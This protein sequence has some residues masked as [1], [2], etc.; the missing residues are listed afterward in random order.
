MFGKS[1]PS[2]E[3]ASP[4]IKPRAPSAP[5]EPLERHPALAV[6]PESKVKPSIISDAVDFVG[7]FRTKGALHV[8]GNARGSIDA[9]CVTVGST[10]SVQGTVHC[11]RLHIKGKFSGDAVC[12]D[13][14]IT[15]EATVE[16]SLT[17]RSILVQRGARIAGDFFVRE[18]AE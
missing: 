15:E 12:D 5:A 18:G 7:E 8:D 10:G 17:F 14:L 2:T 13:L 3:R 9:E 16:G 11:G 6:L 1:K 4:E